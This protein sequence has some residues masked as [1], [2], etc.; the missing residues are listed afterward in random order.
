MSKTNSG[1]AL[2]VKTVLILVAICL[3]CALILAVCNDLFYV[4][5]SE[6]TARKLKAVYADFQTDETFDGKVVE[7]HATDANF[8]TVTEVYRSTDGAYVVKAVGNGG[9]KGKGV[10]VLVAVKSDGVIAGWT[11]TSW[12]GETLSSNFTNKHFSTWYVGQKI[13]TT[14]SAQTDGIVSGTT[15]SS[16]AIAQAMNMASKYLI[17]AYGLG[18]DS[19]K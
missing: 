2:A 11:V 3:I 9:Y 4:S 18:Q 7:E 13:R 15:M 8:G 19:A 14:F 16:G 6:L 10:E 1:A 12:N 17:E 5:P